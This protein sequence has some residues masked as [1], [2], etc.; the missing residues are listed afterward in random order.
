[1]QAA[2]PAI[3]VD[4]KLFGKGPLRQLA[5]ESE[6]PSTDWSDVRLFATTFFAGFL[7]VSILIG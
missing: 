7:L 4:P 1:M 3:A 2:R 6:R 5:A